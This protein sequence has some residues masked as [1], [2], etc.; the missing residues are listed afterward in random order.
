MSPLHPFYLMLPT[1]SAPGV[2]TASFTDYSINEQLLFRMMEE[3]AL[4]RTYEL[5]S[6]DPTIYLAQHPGC[7]I[8]TKAAT[9]FAK[10][11]LFLDE[12]H[13]EPE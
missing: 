4:K 9:V 10:Q 3:K 2:S 12:E 5:Y 8:N 1:A 11:K 13:L 6:I 7:Q